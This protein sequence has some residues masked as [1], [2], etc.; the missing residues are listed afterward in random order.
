MPFQPLIVRNEL[1]HPCSLSQNLVVGELNARAS[2]ESITRAFTVNRPLRWHERLLIRLLLRSPRI[3]K[4][5]IV[6]YGSASQEQCDRIDA[7][8]Q[9][10]HSRQLL[11]QLY[12]A[13]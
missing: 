1:S 8:L 4:V 7:Q 12:R 2:V 11:E 6:Q 3:D 10:K 13:S 5:L 9:Q